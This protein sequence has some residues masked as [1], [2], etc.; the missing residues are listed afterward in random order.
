M[1]T[2]TYA[3]KD[4]RQAQYMQVS[5][6]ARRLV[7]NSHTQRFLRLRWCHFEAFGAYMGNSELRAIDTY[8]YFSRE[9]LTKNTAPDVDS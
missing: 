2:V 1:P 6:R 3:T 9:L 7:T 4:L 8:L 5:F